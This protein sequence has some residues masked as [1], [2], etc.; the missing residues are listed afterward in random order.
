MS[1]VRRLSELLLRHLGTAVDPRLKNNV[2]RRVAQR[3]ALAALGNRLA[4][5]EPIHHGA[6]KLATAAEALPDETIHQIFEEICSVLLVGT[7]LPIQQVRQLIVEA[8]DWYLGICICRQSHRV[9][10]LNHPDSQQVYLLGTPQQRRP[11]MDKLLDTFLEL[12]ERDLVTS[13]QPRSL[14]AELSAKR[15]AETSQ[16]GTPLADDFITRSWPH[17]E[18]LLDHPDFTPAWRKTMIHNRRTWRIHPEILLAWVDLMYF[19]RGVVFTSMNAVDE[20]YTICSCPGPENDGG[21]LLFNWSFYSGN[22]YVL[23]HNQELWHGQ[24]RGSGGQALPCARYEA[25]AERACFGCGCNHADTSKD[26]P[27]PLQ[28]PRPPYQG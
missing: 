7:V 10:D 6:M 16:D 13:E 27:P 19:T 14:L 3:V 17:F 28:D 22:P 5:W 25:R 12:R 23:V 4:A 2:A 8:D 18:I 20:P 1:Q 26:P 9:D 24:R 21:C 11:Y 15:S